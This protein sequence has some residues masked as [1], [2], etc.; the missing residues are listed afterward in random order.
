MHG[1]LKNAR[2]HIFLEYVT[3]VGR[4]REDCLRNFV[5]AD[6]FIEMCIDVGDDGERQGIH[7]QLMR[8]GTAGTVRE[9][10]NH[11]RQISACEFVIFGSVVLLEE[12][13]AFLADLYDRLIHNPLD[14]GEL[15]GEALI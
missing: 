15:F 12:L 8:Q 9:H 13:N 5:D 3:D 10:I 11:F 7:G 4:G 2:V 14:F 6:M 1:K